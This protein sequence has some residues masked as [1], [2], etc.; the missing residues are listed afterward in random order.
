MGGKSI[1]RQLPVNYP[2]NR[3][4]PLLWAKCSVRQNYQETG[5]EYE[6]YEGYSD[7]QGF[8]KYPG[9]YYRIVG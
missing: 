9:Q 6:D 2:S 4:K 8:I 7:F 1:T 3:G 5:V